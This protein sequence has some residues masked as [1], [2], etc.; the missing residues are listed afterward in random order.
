MQELSA[1]ELV[2]Y[3]R[4]LG[5]GVLS[6]EG[7]RRLKGSTALVTRVGG[8]GGPAA[9]SLVMAGVGRVIVAHGGE[10]ISPD[11]NRQVLGSEQDLGQPRAERFAQC[12]RAMNRFVAVEALDHEPDDGE[13]LRLARQADVVLSCP[14][15]FA[16]RLRL[17][18]AAVASGTPLVDAAQWGATGTLLAVRPGHTACLRCLYPEDPPF[19]EMFPVIGAIS[20]AVGSLA[21]LE[22][23]KILAGIGKPL[24]GR[25]WLIDGLRGASSL[26]DLKRN[27]DCPCCGAEGCKGV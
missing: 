23:I 16:E 3:A 15:T 13:A 1:E 8:M 21:A 2:R 20:S 18:R 5:P 10:L 17:N 22:A 25:L 9:M 19:E 11:L 6:E 4:Q 12:L 7:Q 14:P 26:V 27:P 24:F